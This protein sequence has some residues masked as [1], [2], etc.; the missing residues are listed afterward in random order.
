MKCTNFLKSVTEKTERQK[1]TFKI[2]YGIRKQWALLPKQLIKEAEQ[3]Q[4]PQEETP[5]EEDWV[6]GTNR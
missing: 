1:Y 2:L 4:R 6:A 5:D 3:Q